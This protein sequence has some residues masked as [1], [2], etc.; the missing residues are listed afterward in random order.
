MACASAAGPRPY[1]APCPR[2][3]PNSVA[4]QQ[5]SLACDL[6]TSCLQLPVELAFL[7]LEYVDYT[8]ALTARMAKQTDVFGSY[9]TPGTS[10]AMGLLVTDPIPNEAKVELWVV[11]QNVRPRD[12]QKVRGWWRGGEREMEDE[13][14]TGEGFLE[15]LR[16]GDRTMLI[17]RTL[18]SGWVDHV[19]G[20]EVEVRYSG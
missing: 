14:E 19:L 2:L 20:A 1:P 13:K 11:R 9:I 17:G 8:P 6:L 16:E 3:S 4:P 5:V 18:Y 15:A 10:V 12:N 7:I